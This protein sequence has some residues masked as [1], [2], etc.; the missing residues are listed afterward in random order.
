MWDSVSVEEESRLLPIAIE[1]TGDAERYGSF[2]LRV[3]REY[4]YSCEQNLS[5]PS[6]NKRAWIGHAACSLAIQCPE[7]VTRRAWWMLSE[8]QRIAADA[9]ADE[10]IAFWIRNRAQDRQGVLELS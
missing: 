8:E 2:M 6:V 5:N 3:A 1:F 4:T 7:Y 9:K 10:A